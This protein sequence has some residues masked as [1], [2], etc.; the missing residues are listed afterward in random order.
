MDPTPP[1]H[2]QPRVEPSVTTNAVGTHKT[3]KQSRPPHGAVAGDLDLVAGEDSNLIPRVP[4]HFQSRIAGNLGFF[5]PVFKHFSPDFRVSSTII[6]RNEHPPSDWSEA[7]K[8]NRR[9]KLGKAQRRL[10]GV[11]LSDE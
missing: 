11:I 3:M 4:F 8:L 9:Q 10:I 5:V 1:A 6:C 2:R 7:P